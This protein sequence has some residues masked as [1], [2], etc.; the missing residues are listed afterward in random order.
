MLWHA[1]RLAIAV[2]LLGALSRSGAIRWGSLLG[3]LRA[4]PLAGAALVLLFGVLGLTSRRLCVL[5]G[6]RGYRLRL[7]DSLRLTLI[8]AFF[9]TGLPGMAGGDVVRVVYAAGGNP[10]RRAEIATVMGLDKAI[11]L[12]GL[13]VWSLLAALL[14]LPLLAAQPVL[15]GLVG[16]AGLAAATLLAILAVGSHPVLRRARPV[17]WLEGRRPLGGEL[18]RGLETLAHLRRSPRALA[19]ALGLSL[20][21]QAALAAAM[22]LLVGATHPGAARGTML[23]LFPLGFLANALP[24]TPG[25]LGVGEAAFAQL[26]GLAGLE[27]GVEALLAW[28]L[29]TSLLDLSGLFFFLRGQR[30]PISTRADGAESCPS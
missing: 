20:V 26:F 1:L 24:L 15:R 12:L 19:R 29:L 23:A 6:A 22:L 9:N 10:G 25:G 4:W 16:A 27:G 21:A 28:R 30:I 3:L 2:G 11:G 18:A 7:F 17:A 14:A 13:L 5:L 8:G